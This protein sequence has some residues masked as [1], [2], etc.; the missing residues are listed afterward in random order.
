MAIMTSTSRH[1]LQNL[2]RECA[3]ETNAFFRDGQET[4][5]SCMALFRQAIVQRNEQAWEAVYQQYAPLV[6]G[7]VLKHPAFPR[8]G[9][10]AD[11]FVN[12]AFSR[13]WQ[14]ISP[15]K[16]T[17]FGDIKSVLRYLQ[18]CTHSAIVDDLRQRQQM[19]LV[20]IE[21]REV[22]LY[23]DL[24]GQS[25]EERIHHR[26]YSSQ[27]L[28]AA[29]E[30]MK[31]PQERLVLYEAFA[32]GLKPS[33]IIQKHPDTFRDVKEIYRIKENILARLRRDKELQKYLKEMPK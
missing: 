15:S 18:V 25:V 32:L 7:W 2:I 19:E 26:L 13:M 16:F 4:C 28:A 1:R 11:V 21:A 3:R 6:K 31:T 9:E 14:A 10:E 23:L 12:G 17:D 22:Q 8:T 30:R 24:R 33:E 27:A 20:D 5:T 29:L